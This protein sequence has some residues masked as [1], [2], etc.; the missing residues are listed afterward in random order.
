MK[1]TLSLLL[2]AAMLLAIIPCLA[3]S[4]S[5]A[6]TATVTQ[7]LYSEFTIPDG[8]SVVGAKLQSWTNDAT[9]DS[10]ANLSFS[11]FQTYVG[12]TGKNTGEITAI[13]KFY[14]A[15]TVDRIVIRAGYWPSRVSKLE[16]SLSADGENWPTIAN[17]TWTPQNPNNDAN[18]EVVI[19][20]LRD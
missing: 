2:T 17:T 13:G 8:L 9:A 1:R 15:V 14:E 3:F 20:T 6:E 19:I 4:A 12:F 11:S 16:F 7:S 10:F 18:E 5:A